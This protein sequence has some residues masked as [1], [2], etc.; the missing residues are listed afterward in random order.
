MAK[1]LNLTGVRELIFRGD[2]VSYKGVTCLV[3]MHPETTETYLTN[4][5]TGEIVKEY[6]S[7]CCVDMD[8]DVTLL[9]PR[10]NVSV[11]LSK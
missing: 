11:T 4:L 3:S 2:V 7:S 8:E 6:D 1:V 10:D 9:C 5:E